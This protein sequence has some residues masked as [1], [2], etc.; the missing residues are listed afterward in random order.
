VTSPL[1][2]HQNTVVVLDQ[3]KVHKPNLDIAEQMNKNKSKIKR[4]KLSQYK[5]V[6][7]V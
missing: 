2:N 1:A 5:S 4:N 7:P 6:E 3:A